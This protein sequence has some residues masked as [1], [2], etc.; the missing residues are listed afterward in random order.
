MLADSEDYL[1]D[2]FEK[3]QWNSKVRQLQPEDIPRSLQSMALRRNEANLDVVDYEYLQEKRAQITK[4]LQ[5]GWFNDQM[6][7]E[8][9]NQRGLDFPLMIYAEAPELN[10]EQKVPIVGPDSHELILGENLANSL[11]WK[12]YWKLRTKELK[13]MVEDSRNRSNAARDRVLNNKK[14]LTLFKLL[15]K[16]ARKRSSMALKRLAKQTATETSKGS[17]ALLSIPPL[18]TSRMPSTSTC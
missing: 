3:A 12:R 2:N 10:L 7:V 15:S 18:I 6:S 11:L 13:E 5:P 8:K 14:R 16:N 4:G 9:S 17:Q 1:E